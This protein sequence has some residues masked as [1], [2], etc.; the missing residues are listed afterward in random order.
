MIKPEIKIIV[1]I[2]IVGLINHTI[3]IP[4]PTVQLTVMIASRYLKKIVDDFLFRH[5]IKHLAEDYINVK[6]RNFKYD[7][8]LHDADVFV[9]FFGYQGER[10]NKSRR[11]KEEFY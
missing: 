2:R 6:I 10:Y 3:N 11:D 7:W 4:K 8:Y 1:K 5:G 9:E